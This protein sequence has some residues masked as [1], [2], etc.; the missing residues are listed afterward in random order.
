[1]PPCG[2]TIPT[3]ICG[4][5]R[6]DKSKSPASPER[7]LPGFSRGPCRD[8]S[9][10][11]ALFAVLCFRHGHARAGGNGRLQDLLHQRRTDA[12]AA[13]RRVEHADAADPIAA[14]PAFRQ[15]I[16]EAEQLT[17][18]KRAEGDRILQPFAEEHVVERALER[19]VPH[20]KAVPVPGNV[21][22]STRTVADGERFACEGHLIERP[23]LHRAF[24]LCR[25]IVSLIAY[26]RPIVKAGQGAKRPAGIE[27]GLTDGNDRK[28]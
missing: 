17:A 7:D 10:H 11:R 21:P 2:R 6:H 20:G 3:A 18:R 15:A 16:D 26:R 8:R 5:D 12:A 25:L 23:D 14:V 13:R 28:K 1:M 4:F 24:L 9:L 22:V 19:D 27:G